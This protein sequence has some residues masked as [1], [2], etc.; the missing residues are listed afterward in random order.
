MLFCSSFFTSLNTIVFTLP[1][2]R[3]SDGGN[4]SCLSIIS[5]TGFLP[6]HKRLVSDGLSFRAVLVPTKI[7]ASSL[8]HLCTSLLVK[9]WL[10]FTAEKSWLAILPLLLCAHFKII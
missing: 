2:K 8:R 9:S 1:S 10:I 6:C 3:C 4:F 5:L 7:A